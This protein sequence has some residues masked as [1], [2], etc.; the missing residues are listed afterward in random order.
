M[1][2]LTEL[3]IK[4]IPGRQ[5]S[6]SPPQSSIVESLIILAAIGVLTAF[7]VLTGAFAFW[8][9][10]IL[11]LLTVLAIA[12]RCIQA[13]HLL[14][15]SLLWIVLP[16][17]VPVLGSWPQILFLPI[18]IYALVAAAIPNL[19]QSILWLRSGH[20]TSDIIFL[21]LVTIVLSSIALVSWYLLSRPNIGSHLAMIPKMPAWLL[22]LACLGF[23]ILNAAMEEIVFRGIIMQALDSALGAGNLTVVIQVGSFA[24][25]HYLAGFPNGVWGFAMVLIYGFMLGVL[26]RRSQG[27]L[28][29]WIAHVLADI[30][31]FAILATVRF[32]SNTV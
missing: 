31:I 16:L 23:A 22:P 25:F 3:K 4:R 13:I 24:S 26:R 12:F 20:L 15:F 14:S 30:A 28:A 29:P 18:I 11:I 21:I 10:S 1:E 6:K 9:V 32:T 5:E 19:R 17:F 2:S 8:T 7:M 27:I